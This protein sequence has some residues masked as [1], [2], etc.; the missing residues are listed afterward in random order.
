MEIQQQLV[1]IDDGHSETK[2]AYF[3]GA[4]TGA[5]LTTS[6][7]SRT[8]RGY[9]QVTADGTAVKNVYA[10]YEHAE[11]PVPENFEVMTVLQAGASVDGQSENRVADY[12]FSDRN[13]T[14]VH[15]A[16]HSIGS[17][18]DLKIATTLPY[19]DFHDAQTGAQKVRDIARKKENLGK[20]VWSF[21]RSSRVLLPMRAGYRI[22]D[23]SVYS[24]G[25]AAFFDQMLGYDG[26]SITLDEQFA[27]RFRY[28]QDW[29]VV[30]VGGK[31]TDLVYGSWTG[32]PSDGPT[33]NVQKSESLH[34]GLLDAADELR[35]L[36]K[37]R[38]G[39]KRVADP[40]R[41]LLEGTVYHLGD[42]TDITDLTMEAK[43]HLF[44]KIRE[45]IMRKADDG[46]GLAYIIIVGGGATLL[47]EHMTAQFPEKLT[48]IPEDPRFANA[49]G[50]LKLMRLD[51][52]LEQ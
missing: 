20:A 6:F 8:L 22:T 51:A 52:D 25:V 43:N 32:D 4:N 28:V 49:R 33:I 19:G 48:R 2:V 10:V 45:P 13:R 37:A 31:T 26:S 42:M 27:S 47:R 50:M 39:I 44:S 34:C 15:H 12:P 18:G 29:L 38:F 30:D 5:I 9:N 16:L 1:A 40:E 46:S 23:Q 3:S 24:E 21:D 7:P 36:I 17:S 14:L 41:C 35:D 11:P